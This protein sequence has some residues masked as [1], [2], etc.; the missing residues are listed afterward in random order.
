MPMTSTMRN[1]HDILMDRLKIT[2]DIAA[3]NVE[4]LRLN[5]IAG[6]MMVLDMK[7][8]NDGVT[9]TG[10]DTERNE[11]YRALEVN[12]EKINALEADLALLDKEL[13]AA[14]EEDEK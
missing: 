12:L 6:G 14:V 5:Q 4:Q 3:A 13:E 10:R 7:D 11:N 2:Q 8:E 9:E 1:I